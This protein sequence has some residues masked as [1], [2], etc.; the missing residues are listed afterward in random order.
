MYKQLI[1]SV[2]HCEV[3]KQLTGSVKHLTQSLVAAASPPQKKAERSGKRGF[4]G[5]SPR[6]PNQ[7]LRRR[8]RAQ[9][10]AGVL[11]SVQRSTASAATTRSASQDLRACICF[12][13][14]AYTARS[15]TQRA[16]LHSAQ[17]CTACSAAQRAA[18]H[19]AGRYTAPSASL[20]TALYSAQ[21]CTPP[22]SSAAQR[23]ALH[24]TRH[25]TAPS[26][27]SQRIENAKER[28]SAWP[29]VVFMEP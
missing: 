24:S 18:L 3:R 1:G 11:R 21:H 5:G 2:K 15:A 22:P 29:S 12:Q 6:L 8:S 9:R 7:A 16:A 27:A 23:A 14:S 26:T 10:H 20:R 28:P 4:G 17:R 13:R 19:S 25:Y